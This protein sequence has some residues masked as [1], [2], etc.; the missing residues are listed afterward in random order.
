MS[1]SRGL[2]VPGAQSGNETQFFF[3]ESD[4]RQSDADDRVIRP[5]LG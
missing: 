1:N 2:C 3:S 5:A 4:V